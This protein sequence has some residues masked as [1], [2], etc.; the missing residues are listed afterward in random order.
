M[1]Q[2]QPRMAEPEPGGGLF[3][4]G[5]ADVNAAANP[6]RVLELLRYLYEPA[7]VQAGGVLE[8]DNRAIGALAKA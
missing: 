4:T 5:V 2:A 3:D 1:S 7:Q 8:E 6:L